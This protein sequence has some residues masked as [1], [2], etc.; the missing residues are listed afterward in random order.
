MNGLRLVAGSACILIS[1]CAFPRT[2]A[3]Q[4]C[5]GI[6]IGP[7]E[8]EVSAFVELEDE[9]WLGLQYSRSSRVVAWGVEVGG[10][11]EESPGGDF[12]DGLHPFAGARVAW[13]MMPGFCPVARVRH[14]REV[15][16]S[17]S[18]RPAD[19]EESTTI[20]TVGIGAGHVVEGMRMSPTLYM[21]PQVRFLRRHLVDGEIDRIDF[22]TRFELEGG[23]AITGSRLWAG[24]GIR[25]RYR[26]GLEYPLTARLLVRGGIRL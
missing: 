1:I 17:F 12:P 3:A 8:H 16:D 7:G 13:L 14:T 10:S 24:G 9:T 25:V 18:V 22:E 11:A 21:L 6:P 20:W 2:G 23:G 19:S 5:L 4:D 15:L 26:E